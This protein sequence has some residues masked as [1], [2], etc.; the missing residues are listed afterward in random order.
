MLGQCSSTLL[1]HN[2]LAIYTNN[3][4]NNCDNCLWYSTLPVLLLW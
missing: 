3:L 4:T 1:A 2:A